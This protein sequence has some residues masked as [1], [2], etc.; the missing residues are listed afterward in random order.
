MPGFGSPSGSGAAAGAASG[1]I[2]GPLGSIGG[3]LLGGIFSAKGQSDANKAN[4]RIAQE[5]RAFQER[6]SN[7]AIQRRMAD[8]RAAGL[9]PILAG[10]HDASTPAGAMATMGNVGAAAVE[11]TERGANTAKSRAAT[12]KLTLEQDHITANIDLM[13]K[14]KGLLLEQ[15][16]SAEEHAKQARIQT[17]LDEQ[18]KLLDAEIYK[19][20]EG[21]VLRRAQL[22]QSPANTAR[23]IA[24]NW[25]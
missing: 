24:P 9:N 18:L 6:M 23:Q 10:R 8:L 22:W 25:R 21:K 5:N 19:G 2:L 4:L 14:Q 17:A 13:A 1:S 16:N 20:K 12:K 15:T 11:G 3:A 7:T